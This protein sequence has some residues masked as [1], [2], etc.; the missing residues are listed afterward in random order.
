MLLK[1]LGVKDLFGEILQFADI[2]DFSKKLD[3][4]IILFI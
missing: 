4:I 3:I 2:L 1:I